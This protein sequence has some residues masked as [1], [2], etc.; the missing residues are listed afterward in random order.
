MAPRNWYFLLC[1]VV[2]WVF[3]ATPAL[4]QG[5]AGSSP[6][7]S[8]DLIGAPAADLAAKRT[9]SAGPFHDLAG[10]WAI[11]P[12]HNLAGPSIDA[13]PDP[14]A[15]PS[16]EASRDQSTADNADSCPGGVCSLVGLDE[17]RR[18]TRRLFGRRRAR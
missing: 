1:A 11:A 5:G 2:L 4:S 17:D 7:R 14:P 16:P 8:F 15:A 18:T 9:A 3:G 12:R 10:H 6:S 13:F